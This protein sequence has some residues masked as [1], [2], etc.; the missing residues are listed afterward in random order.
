M[1][2]AIDMEAKAVLDGENSAFIMGAG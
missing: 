2:Q 1:I